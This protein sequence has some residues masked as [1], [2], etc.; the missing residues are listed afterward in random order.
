MDLHILKTLDEIKDLKGEIRAGGTDIHDRLRLGIKLKDS[1]D[2]IVDIFKI[3][4]LNNIEQQEDGSVTLGAL[5]TIDQI[6]NNPLILEKYSGL[7]KAANGLATP[8]IRSV[9]TL[10]G[11]LL[12]KTRCPYFRHPNLKCVKKGDDVCGGHKGNHTNGVVF[13]KGG[14]SHPHASTLAIALM[15]YDAKIKTTKREL[16]IFDLYGNGSDGTKDHL[17]K[18]NEVLTNVV[19]SSIPNGVVEKTTYFRS[20]SRFEAEWPIVECMVR[21]VLEDEKIIDVGIGVGGVSQVPMRFKNVENAL[22]GKKAS[23]ENFK[24]VSEKVVEGANPLPNAAWKLKML[25][26]TLFTALEMSLT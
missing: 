21:L 6:A 14:C 12:Q 2:N 19:L 15:A 17:L 8:Q 9:A 1:S 26:G 10:G 4:D 16:N 18:D 5:T 20:I 13:D 3:P 24:L 25:E 7:A 22:V 11:N 23:L